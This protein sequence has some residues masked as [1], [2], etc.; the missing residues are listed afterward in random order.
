[1]WTDTR[2]APV[3]LARVSEYGALA[4]AGGGVLVRP[5]AGAAYA[6]DAHPSTAMLGFFETPEFLVEASGA[7]VGPGFRWE[8]LAVPALSTDCRTT[9][10]GPPGAWSFHLTGVVANGDPL[11]LVWLDM[12]PPE[13]AGAAFLGRVPAVA[14]ERGP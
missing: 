9:L 11:T 7:V 4:A 8:C 10:R 13:V 12:E 3:M 5:H 6:L 14:A 1:M 2:Q